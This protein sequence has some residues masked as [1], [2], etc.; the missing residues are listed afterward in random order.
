MLRIQFKSFHTQH[1]RVNTWLLHIYYFT[2][3]WVTI[4][5]LK[6][7]CE[8]PTA[9]APPTQN[10]GKGIGRSGSP[11][12]HRLRLHSSSSN[13]IS[14]VPERRC[15]ISPLGG[16][17]GLTFKKTSRRP[18]SFSRSLSFLKKLSVRLYP[19]MRSV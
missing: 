14:L 2:R 7:V 1:N 3:L 16:E 15:H 6:T 8:E 19:K 12:I 5:T 13:T 9:C 17:Q 4:N 10:P 18:T 11:G